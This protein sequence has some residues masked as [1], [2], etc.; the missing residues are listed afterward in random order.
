VGKDLTKDL[1]RET[2]VV[3]VTIH[4]EV[5]VAVGA[6]VVHSWIENSAE[7]R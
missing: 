4:Q 6:F 1:E 5:R 3:V 2:A 7:D